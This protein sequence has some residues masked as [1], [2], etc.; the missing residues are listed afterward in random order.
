MNVRSTVILT[1]LVGAVVSTVFREPALAQGNTPRNYQAPLVF[2]AA[3]PAA[4]SIAGVVDQFRAALGGINNGNG[5]PQ[6]SGR[7]EINWDGGGSATS[8]GTTPFT[9]FLNN[10]G[11]F[12]TTPGSGFVQ[13][14][15]AGLGDTFGNSSY[16]SAFQ[17]FSLQR[18]FSPIG[19]NTTELRFFLPGGNNVAAVT[20]GFG[21]V[22]SDVDQ[23]DGSGPASK[24]GNRGAS[25]YIEYYD[26]YG[27]LL[28][29]STVAASPGDATF[30][31][32]GV[33]FDSA[34]IGGVRIITGDVAPG[35]DDQPNHDVVVMDD[36]IYGEPKAIQ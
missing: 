35:P 10:R 19:S 1:A 22:L 26:A 11:A 23:P 8:V 7:R 13:A 36:F 29:S 6:Q 16:A 34:R 14:P 31:F 3:G 27:Q 24:R 30:T 15:P 32:I 33:L 12:L 18:L 28:Y 21:V 9:V 25:T 20:S 17:P 4:A 2:Q 5:A